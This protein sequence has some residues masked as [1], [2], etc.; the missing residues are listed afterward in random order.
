MLQHLNS[1]AIWQT[2]LC[3]EENLSDLNKALKDDKNNEIQDVSEK[4]LKISIAK[5]NPQKL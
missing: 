5:K 4:T 2:T 1:I 3:E